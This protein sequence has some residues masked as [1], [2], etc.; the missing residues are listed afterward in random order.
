MDIYFESRQMGKSNRKSESMGGQVVE[1]RF[2]E[3]A[4]YWDGNFLHMYIHTYDNEK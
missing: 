3:R 2:F 4:G 1:R